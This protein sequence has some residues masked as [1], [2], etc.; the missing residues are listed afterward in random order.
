MEPL[1]WMVVNLCKH[2][3]ERGYPRLL[4]AL[5]MYLIYVVVRL[6]P[7]GLQDE[8]TLDAREITFNVSKYAPGSNFDKVRARPP[9]YNNKNLAPATTM[10][11]TSLPP[12]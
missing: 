10:T 2:T 5:L 1:L 11:T 3:F 7:T 6:Q 4:V 9:H 8:Q 12:H